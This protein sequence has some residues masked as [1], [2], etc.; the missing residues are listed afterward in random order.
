MPLVVLFQWN[1]HDEQILSLSKL[2]SEVVVSIQAVTLKQFRGSAVDVTG[3]DLRW[4]PREKGRI[5]SSCCSRRR[6]KLEEDFFDVRVG[7]VLG[8]TE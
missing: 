5:R 2:G 1:F 7:H 6:K 4:G 3:I 8:V